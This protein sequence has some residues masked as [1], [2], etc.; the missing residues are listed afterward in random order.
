MKYRVVESD[1]GVFVLFARTNHLARL[2]FYSVSGEDAVAAVCREFPDA[3]ETPDM[4]GGDA[5]L[6]K[7]YVRGEEVEFTLPV[8]LSALKPFT[9][10]VLTE[11]RR[12]PYGRTASYGAVARDLGYAG[13]A[14]AVG[15]A[16]KRNPIPLVIPCHRVIREDGSLGGFSMGLDMKIRLLL[17]EGIPVDSPHKSMIPS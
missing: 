1:L 6:L 12:I 5:E 13:A 10:R 4:L 14:R 2:D 16:L 9:A 7:R 3:V 15:Q 11:I 17:L 8:D